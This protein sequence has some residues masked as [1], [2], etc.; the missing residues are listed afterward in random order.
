[1]KIKCFAGLT[2]LIAILFL[3]PTVIAA[4]TYSGGD[5]LSMETAYQISTVADMQDIGDNPDDWASFFIVTGNIDFGANSDT[6]FFPIGSDETKFTGT[7]DGGGHTIDNFSYSTIDGRN[8]GLFGVV[9]KGGKV[10]NLGLTNVTIDSGTAQ[11]TASLVGFN[12]GGIVRNCFS[13]GSVAGVDMVGGLV[14]RSSYGIVAE[15]YSAC[16]VNANYYVGGL[17][18]KN[19]FSV[20]TDCYTT[21]D[22]TAT[23]GT[24]G[25][26]AGTNAGGVI[27][28]SYSIAQL[29]AAGDNVGGLAGASSGIIANCYTEGSVTGKVLV[30]GLVGAGTKGNITNCYS[31]CSVNGERYVGGLIGDAYYGNAINSYSCGLVTGTEFVGGLVGGRCNVRECYFLDTSGPNN[32]LGT[33]LPEH[34]MR[35]QGS[36]R[37]WDFVGSIAGGVSEIWQMPTGGGY[38]VLSIFNGYRPALDGSGTEADPFLISEPKDLGAI[39]HYSN[40]SFKLTNDIDLFGI[41]WFTSVIPVLTGTVDGNCHVIKSL[42]IDGAGFTGLFGAL[43]PDGVISNLALEQAMVNSNGDFVGAL[44]GRN[45]G[46]ITDCHS[47]GAVSGSFSVGGLLGENMNGSV[48]ECSSSC[49][50]VF[51][52]RFV[53]GLLGENNE[54]TVTDSYSISAVRGSDYAGGLT[55]KNASN[56][57]ITNC[58]ATGEVTGTG[59]RVG[60]LVGSNSGRSG[61]DVSY[62]TGH[63]NGTGDRVGGLVGDN[64]YGDITDCYATGP[65]DGDD[66][67]GGLVGVNDYGSKVLRN[68]SVGSVTGTASRVGGLVGYNYASVRDSYFL[69]STGPDNGYGMPLADSAMKLQASFAGWDFNIESANGTDDIWHIPYQDSGYP[70]LFFQRDIP[71]D[72]LGV[73][74]VDIVDARLLFARFGETDCA[75]KNE[76]DGADIDLSGTVDI[77]DLATVMV[78]WLEGK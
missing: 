55:G 47:S 71:G 74:G 38:P 64:S 66:F 22:V 65:V 44:V 15:S 49:F 9:G 4:G 2:I 24:V 7:F 25:G 6:F 72:L 40:A 11:H 57:S 19:Y 23:G 5:G 29:D 37:N 76:C 51:G 16:S 73:Y 32:R 58:Y 67:V 70:K 14:G 69:D 52:G 68:Y 21:G 26:L 45:Y 46:S 30:G 62:A 43:G 31:V 54:G 39:Y 8:V 75:S 48:T 42:K 1:M 60:G 17:V 20:I 78:H 12:D 28:N 59:D 18:A 56:S 13:S 35:Q 36:F 77:V 33:A 10:K 27:A 3:T 63:V 61:I 50:I 53:G 41:E 34:L